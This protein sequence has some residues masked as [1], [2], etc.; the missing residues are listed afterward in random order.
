MDE[1]KPLA[2][3]DTRF[4]A[5]KFR[6]NHLVDTRTEEI[7]VDKYIGCYITKPSA[8]ALSHRMGRRAMATATDTAMPLR[9]C[10]KMCENC[11]AEQ[12]LPA[13]PFAPF[14]NVPL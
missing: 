11:R 4:P 10:V 7:H 2:S 6:Y 9:R 3:G 8:P 14:T 12:T 13:T 5:W 1:C